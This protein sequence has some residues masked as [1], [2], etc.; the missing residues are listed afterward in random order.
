MR[1]MKETAQCSDFCSRNVPSLTRQ[2]SP[3]PQHSV[4]GRGPSLSSHPAEALQPALG[5][6][7]L[8][9]VSCSVWFFKGHSKT[10]YSKSAIQKGTILVELWTQRWF[11]KVSPEKIR[12]EWANQD[13]LDGLPPHPWMR[14]IYFSS[15]TFLGAYSLLEK[16][17]LVFC[18]HR[19]LNY[20][21]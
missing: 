5:P 19:W 7:R 20:V 10:S 14:S 18:V 9:A 1:K 17:F 13:F 8:L 21:K 16:Y 2:M 15:E 4:N 3:L 12:K 11:L 6:A